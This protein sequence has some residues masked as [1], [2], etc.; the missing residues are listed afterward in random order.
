MNQEMGHLTAIFLVS[1]D[2][3]YGNKV[4]FQ[5]P[6]DVDLSGV[7][8]KALPSGFHSVDKDLM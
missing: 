7:E 3:K 5:I 8:F 6:N 1:F 4:E 2:T